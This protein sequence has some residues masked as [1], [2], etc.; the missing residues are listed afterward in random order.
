M[1]DNRESTSPILFLGISKTYLQ[2]F[3]IIWEA[4]FANTHRFRW[5]LATLLHPVS[6]LLG[7]SLETALKGLLSC[8]SGNVPRTHNLM[9]LLR[10]VSDSDILSSLDTELVELPVPPDLFEVNPEASPAEIEGFYRRHHFHFDMLNA[11][12]DRPYATR[13]P[14]LGGPALPDAIALHRLIRV[15]QERLSLDASRWR[16]GSQPR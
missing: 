4:R 14:V 2:A 13:Y 7:V 10:K 1:A 8:R 9:D 5:D 15:L 12:Y 3:E 16:R 6:H 11:V